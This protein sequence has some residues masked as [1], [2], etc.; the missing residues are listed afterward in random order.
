M[1][2]SQNT[3]RRLKLKALSEQG[4]NPF[5]HR[6]DGL[7]SVSVI[8]NDFQSFEGKVV[9][10]AGRMMAFRDHGK[11]RFF[12]L[13]ESTGRIQCY[14]RK[15]DIGDEMYEISSLLDIGDFVFVEGTV[16]KTR[17]GEITVFAVKFE[18]M[19][20]SLRTL[21]A[22]WHGLKDVEIKYR[23]RYLDLIANRESFDTLRLRSEIVREY[24]R[25]F[26]EKGFIE[27]ETPSMHA[28]PGG[29]SARPFI[30]H[31][32]TLDCDLY[33]RIAEE[34]YLKR[35]LIGGFEKVFEVG[36]C[37]RNEG[38]STRHNPEFTMSEVYEAYADYNTMMDHC[39]A[40]VARI[41]EHVLGKTEV[42][43]SGQVI[44]FK[45]PWR[46]AKFIDLIAETAKIDPW[47]EQAA[48]ESLAKSGLAKED[49]PK[50]H[51]FVLQELFERYI[52][53]TLVQPTFVL[54]HPAATTPLCR[55]LPSDQRLVERFELFVAGMEM[56]N[57]YTEL[58][59][60]EIQRKNFIEQIARGG[61]ETIGKLDEDF[62]IAMEHGMPPAG[63]M[64]I[65]IDRLVMLLTG[66]SSIRDVIFFPLLRPKDEAEISA[67]IDRAEESEGQ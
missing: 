28:I 23:R 47:D 22:K 55:A 39:E 43:F 40:V 7:T 50:E 57:A 64:G 10:V 12:D 51:D 18:L 3:D 21:P 65:G 30:T 67:E 31:H 33:L 36:K 20:K 42:E 63:G 54:D 14:I 60:P 37:F 17:M 24:R 9:R 25:Y 6:I 32:N 49:Q 52:E 11:S 35:L 62:I 27:V 26:E 1:D 4:I 16:G 58:N 41:C 8:K 5:G 29:A 61:E 48:R 53:A 2:T 44:N 59:D 13:L 56:A 15:Q 38:I 34:L 19:A 46:R 66:K 45:T